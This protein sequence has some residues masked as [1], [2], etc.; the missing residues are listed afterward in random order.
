MP[1]VTDIQ[2]ASK[3]LGALIVKVCTWFRLRSTMTG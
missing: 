1:S 3:L 2:E